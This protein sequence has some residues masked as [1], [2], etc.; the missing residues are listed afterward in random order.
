M[1]EAGDLLAVLGRAA[2]D[3]GY[4]AQLFEKGSR[5]LGEYDLTLEEEAALLSGDIRWIEERFGPLSETLKRWL[6]C[7]L[8]TER[9]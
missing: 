8:Q 1:G 9:W 2:E 6:I 7:R 5:A 3:G 4:L